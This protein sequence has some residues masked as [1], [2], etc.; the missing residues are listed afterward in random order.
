MDLLDPPSIRC[1]THLVE[2]G[3][4]QFSA[5][6]SA[7]N[8]RKTKKA[9]LKENKENL[10]LYIIFQIINNNNIN[11][12]FKSILLDI[13]NLINIILN[14]YNNSNKIYCNM[15]HPQQP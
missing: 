15:I 11:L 10:R 2:G 1:E 14:N 5:C 4:I 9:V 13:L 8:S 3:I 12:K 7:V 6:L